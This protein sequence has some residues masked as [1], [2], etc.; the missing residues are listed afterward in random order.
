MPLLAYVSVTNVCVCKSVCKRDTVAVHFIPN[1]NK[2]EGTGIF[3]YTPSILD[4]KQLLSNMV[5]HKATQ[6]IAKI[7]Y[8]AIVD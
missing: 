2:Q 8:Q 6:V 7:F 3:I 5:D 1:N 4:N